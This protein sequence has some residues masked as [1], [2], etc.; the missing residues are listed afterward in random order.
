MKPRK[1]KNIEIGEVSLVDKPANKKK[2]LLFKRAKK[3]K[4]WPSLT[5]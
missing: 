3:K 1:L 4:L 5:G 2:F